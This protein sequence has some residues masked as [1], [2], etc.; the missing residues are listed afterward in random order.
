MCNFLIFQPNIQVESFK[1]NILSSLYK[2]WKK[3]DIYRM[4]SRFCNLTLLFYDLK[5]S[6]NTWML[7]LKW[8]SNFLAILK[9]CVLLFVQLLHNSIAL[10][11]QKAKKIYCNLQ[12]TSFSCEVYSFVI[13]NSI[14]LFL[15][16]S[17]QTVI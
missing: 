1:L 12:V 2:A 3:K 17:K 10:R 5:C 8:N 4:I 11:F 14:I 9:K 7:Y 6:T 13:I 15:F 16:F